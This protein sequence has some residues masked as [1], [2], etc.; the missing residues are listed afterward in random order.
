MTYNEL[1][2]QLF[3][4]MKEMKVADDGFTNRVMQQLPQ[5][6]VRRLSRLWTVFCVIVAVVLFVM[7]RGWDILVYGLLML[8]NTPPTSQQILTFAF[9]VG[10]IG[11]LALSEVVSRVRCETY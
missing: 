5:R 1:L 9:S 4:P 2:E 10:I 7:M 8:A 11:L 3:Q 6:D